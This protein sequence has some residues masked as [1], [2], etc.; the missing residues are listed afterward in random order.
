MKRRLLLPWLALSACAV[1]LGL[2][3]GA[4]A[5]WLL[6]S[7]GT[8]IEIRGEWRVAGDRVVF[9]LTS[10]TLG[11]LPVT[12]VDLE[13]T[14]RLAEESRRPPAPVVAPVRRE[15]LAV[16][17]D[18]DVPRAPVEEPGFPRLPLVEHTGNAASAE[19][20]NLAA[21]ASTGDFEIAYWTGP[22]SPEVGELEVLGTLRNLQEISAARVHLLVRAYDG[23]E[24][25]EVAPA[26]LS[27]PRIPALG[28]TGFRAVLP[29]VAPGT[30][31]ELVL[32]TVRAGGATLP[33]WHE[34]AFE[35][36]P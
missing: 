20:R 25:L 24:L 2:P 17:R 33:P 6:L 22:Y 10:G 4:S 32:M 30:R 7:D 9:H 21:R 34:P 5:D 23:D 28:S 11:A 31:L 8:R 3:A 15:P 1:P 26:R 19:P 12:E 35:D 27:E 14:E 13:A 18:G 29:G 16:L 36:Q